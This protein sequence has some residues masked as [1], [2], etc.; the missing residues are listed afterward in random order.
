MTI[1]VS[2]SSCYTSVLKVGATGVGQ[3][4]SVWT[5]RGHLLELFSTRVELL[6]SSSRLSKSA[7]CK[8]G[9]FLCV[10][11]PDDS[12]SLDVIMEGKLKEMKIT[13][14]KKIAGLFLA[15]PTPAMHVHTY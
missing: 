3:S 5:M 10:H 11:G 14:V 7:A 1:I 6:H 2:L 12:E 8:T 13:I 4:P 15:V 9:K